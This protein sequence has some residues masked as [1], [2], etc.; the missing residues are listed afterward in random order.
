MTLRELLGQT[1]AA[2]RDIYPSGEARGIAWWI[3]EEMTGMSRT[4]LL[5]SDSG[6]D[7]KGLDDVT[8]RLREGEPVQ[9]IFGHTVWRGLDLKL[10]NST[11]IP[12]PETAELADWVLQEHEGTQRLRVLDAGTG[13]GCIAI[14]LK[15]ERTNWEVTGI[16]ISETALEAAAENSRRN[17]A[18]VMWKQCDMTADETWHGEGWDIITSNPPYVRESEKMSMKPWVLNHEP[19]NALFVTDDDPLKFYRAIVSRKKAREVYF[20][21]NEALATETTALLHKYGYTDTE[22]RL[23]IYG[24]ERMVR[25]RLVC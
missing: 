21:V 17:G 25:G 22:T 5:L 13:S 2:L 1:E 11:L 10:N 6:I 19:H 16:D 18:D 15:K 23:D 7:A 24:K 3:A 8:R 9:Y 12:R 14:A 20:E 4:E